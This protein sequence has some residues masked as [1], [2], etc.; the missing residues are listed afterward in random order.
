MIINSLDFCYVLVYVLFPCIFFGKIIL[1]H[2]TEKVCIYLCD[3]PGR[4][5]TYEKILLP[6]LLII[7]SDLFWNKRCTARRMHSNI[8]LLLSNGKTPIFYPFHFFFMTNPLYKYWPIVHIIAKYMLK[9]IDCQ[10]EGFL[11]I[12]TLLSKSLHVPL[13][14][15]PRPCLLTVL[16]SGQFWRP[17]SKWPIWLSHF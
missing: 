7:F 15:L 16:A 6:R 4:R 2:L 1:W 13:H 3:I 8:S 11:H 17:S 10:K 5:Q 14:D 12:L 9:L